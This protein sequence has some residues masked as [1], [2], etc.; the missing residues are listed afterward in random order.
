MNISTKQKGA[1]NQKPNFLTAPYFCLLNNVF[2][3]NPIINPKN[4][5]PIITNGI[6][7]PDKNIFNSLFNLISAK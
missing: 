7:S 1:R 3:S 5:N 2:I 6:I 4:I